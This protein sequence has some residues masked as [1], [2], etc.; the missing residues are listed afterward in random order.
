MVPPCD[1]PAHEND[2]AAAVYDVMEIL[3]YI[4]NFYQELSLLNLN[5]NFLLDLHIFL[6]LS[7]SLPS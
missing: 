1:H 2:A 6:S 7:V 4:Y 5:L 3:Q